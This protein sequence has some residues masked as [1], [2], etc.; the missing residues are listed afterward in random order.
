MRYAGAKWDGQQ[1]SP[2][3]PALQLPVLESHQIP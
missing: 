3:N 1:G 2:P